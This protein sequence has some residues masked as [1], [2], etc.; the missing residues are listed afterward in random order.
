MGMFNEPGP[1]SEPFYGGRKPTPRS[2]RIVSLQNSMAQAERDQHPRQRPLM[3]PLYLSSPA[4]NLAAM[5]S[6]TNF[7]F[8]YHIRLSA[9]AQEHGNLRDGLA[10]TF[11]YYSQN[12]PT[13][14][15]LLPRAALS[16][17]LLLAFWSPQAG[18]LA[19]ADAGISPRDGTFFRASDQTLTNYARGVLIA[20]A[21]WTAWRVLVL[22]LSWIGVWVFSGQGCAGICG[23]RYRWEEDDVE[24]T[25][26][27]FADN[28]SDTDVLPWSWRECTLLRV[29]DAYEFCLTNKHPRTAGE[30]KECT[31]SDSRGGTAPYEGMDKVFAAIGLGGG[32]QPARRGV[33]SDDLFASPEPEEEPEEPSHQATVALPAPAVQAREKHTSGPSGPL[34]KLPYPFVGHKAQVSS[35]DVIPFPPSPE[36]EEDREVPISDGVEGDEDEEE[37][38]EGEEESEDAESE[39]RSEGR[40]TSG[41]MSSLGRPVSSSRYP[42]QFRK[43]PARGGSVSSASHMGPH[44][45]STPHSNQTRSTPSRSTQSRSTRHSQ[46]THSTGNRESSDSPYPQSSNAPS[47]LSI[48]G[49]GIPMPPRHPQ[50]RARAGTVPTSSI[51]SS[52]SP[53]SF[54][55]RQR[56]RAR[57]DSAQTGTESVGTDM[58]MTFGPLPLA[59][60][61]DNAEPPHDESLM[62]VPEAEGSIEEAE[63][64]DSV[65]LLSAGTSPRASRTSLVNRLGGA[66]HR[67]ANGSRSRSGTGSRSN[68]RSRT[69]SSNSRSESARSRA[70]SLI[71]S[72][73]AASR[74][75]LELVRSRANSMARLSDSPYYSTSPDPIPSS[76]ENNTFG[77]PLRTGWR[78]EG[79]RE[80]QD[81]DH[82]I[83]DTAELPSPSGSVPRSRASSGNVSVMGEENTVLRTAR[84]RHMSEISRTAPSERHSEWSVQTARADVVPPSPSV[85]VDIPGRIVHTEQSMPDISTAAPSLVTAPA[86]VEGTTDTSG[87]TPSSW[88]TVGR[89]LSGPE[90][91]EPA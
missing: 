79:Q 24:K 80:A 28:L 89:Y 5:T 70:Q 45:V 44:Q 68:S 10:E 30:K 17:A 32:P 84:R 56:V 59:Y 25:V 3:L 57:A 6:Y 34:T 14:A 43:P 38:Q 26:S 19:L 46:S 20:N 35:E 62:D 41:S 74:S 47:P 53:I 87:R 60:D 50:R 77:H 67:R 55:G 21:A 83:S 33:L 65:G 9:F 1:S 40:R 49:S 29:V 2:V 58:S 37:E 16:L 11:Y 51:P 81:D 27:A 86:T 73:G 8:L 36:P 54:P 82:D 18:E 52:P 71:Q 15:L 7:C 69:N 72:L 88:G 90:R 61:L 42:F 31:P 63:Q 85:P 39:G 48:S 22:F 12:L 13:V 76:P 4:F 66:T 78:T 64:H 91:H 75:S 23:P